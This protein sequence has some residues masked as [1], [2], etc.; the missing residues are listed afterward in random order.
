[1]LLWK[2]LRI[3]IFSSRSEIML[4]SLGIIRK[5]FGDVMEDHGRR[6]M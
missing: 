4:R 6:F 5:K 3:Q 2:A 1:M